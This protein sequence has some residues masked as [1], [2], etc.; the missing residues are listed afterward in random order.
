MHMR[1][2]LALRAEQSLQLR[3]ALL[4]SIEVLQMAAVD[5][6]QRIDRELEA[7]ETLLALPREPEIAAASADSGR[8]ETFGD[9]AWRGARSGGETDA[10]QAML[11][12]APAPGGGLAAHCREQ[13][14]WLGV[15]PWLREGVELLIGCLDARGL[16]A[17]AGDELAHVVGAQ[18]L[19]P[20]LELLAALEPRG[21]GARTPV[22]AMLAQIDADD[23]DRAAIGALLTQH[24]E[25]LAR[26]RLPEVARALQRPVAEIEALVARIRGL[27]P[28]PGARFREERNPAV[29]PDL[30]VREEHGEV[31]VIVDDNELPALALDPE[32]EAM[33][34]SAAAGS[35]LRRYL[36]RKI[37]V[38]RDLIEAVANRK[39]TLARVGAAV[40]ER[41]PQFLERGLAALRP[42]KMA[43][44][45]AAL[46][47]HVSTVSR[48]VAGKYLQSDR[49]LFRL[50]DLFDG[51]DSGSDQAVGRGAIKH[52][53]GELVAAEDRAAPLSDDDLAAMLGRQGIDVSRRTVAKYRSELRIRSSWRRRVFTEKEERT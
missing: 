19:A 31:R 37:S 53:I 8:D 17:A 30:V 48:A 38:A 14:V 27:D 52:R 15:D 2:D 50:R 43:D 34:A 1:T 44:I 51:G 18:R 40:L 39:H 35:E 25:A 23:P 5:L 41:Q 16:L 20:C 29:R 36:G 32:Y 13:L 10:K 7:N 33:A 46:D 42:M 28:A 49:G 22:E 24:L 9:D 6:L 26:N 45:A 12:S 4:L 3:P 47:L 21:L 11:S